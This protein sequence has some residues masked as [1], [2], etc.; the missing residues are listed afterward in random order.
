MPDETQPLDPVRA[1]LEQSRTGFTKT[2]TPIEAGMAGS[3]FTATDSVAEF[4]GDLLDDAPGDDRTDNAMRSRLEAYRKADDLNWLLEGAARGTRGQSGAEPGQ[5]PG[6]NEQAPQGS[7]PFVARAFRNVAEIP[8]A[9]IGG[10][11]DAMQAML[12]LGAEF[13][14]RMKA[15]GLTWDD[16]G[17]LQIQN[18]EGF[19]AWK[20]KRGGKGV[21][22]P[23][24]GEQRT[25]TGKAARVISQFMAPFWRR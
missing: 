21:Q 7:E 22:L 11:R 15:G 10:G 3:P 12:D 24:V 14:D 25:M 19:A 5:L 9:V 23:D 18:A 4:D 1:F 6:A 17:N 8:R 2:G 16:G 13:D 20:Q